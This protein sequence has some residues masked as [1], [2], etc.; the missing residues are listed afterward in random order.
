MKLVLQIAILLWLIVCAPPT[1]A[2]APFSCDPSF[3]ARQ[4]RGGLDPELTT[5]IALTARRF[6]KERAETFWQK[7][8]RSDYLCIDLNCISDEEIAARVGKRCTAEPGQTLEQAAKEV[9]FYE[10]IHEACEH[11]LIKI[12]PISGLASSG[13]APC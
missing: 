3:E 12:K 2:Q 6:A 5:W 10:A 8:S 4:Q 13:F 1:H 11:G 7:W 9:S